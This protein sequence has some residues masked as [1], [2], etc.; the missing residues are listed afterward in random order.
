MFNIC[1]S[2]MTG[3]GKSTL[4]RKLA[5]RYGL[6]VVSGGEILKEII[7]GKESLRDPGWWEREQGEAALERRLED[8]RYDLE[9]DRR[10]MELAKEGGYILDSWTMAYLLDRD[11]CIK[12]FLKADFESR[13][14][15]VAER[16]KISIEEAKRRIMI[17]EERSYKIYKGL[18]GFDIG[19][20]LSPFHLVIDTTGLSPDDVFRVVST[21]ID[22]LL[23][24]GNTFP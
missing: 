19:K 18:Y 4:A 10:L 12:I 11:S 6:K 24:M 17:K 21:Y 22:C 7:A 15:R 16:D 3:T 1:L 5:E 23:N 8:S 20:D 2:G 13:A 14:L 9:V